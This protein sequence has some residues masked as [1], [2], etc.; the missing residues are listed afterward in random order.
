MY[1]FCGM[2]Y[3]YVHCVY[4]IF[5]LSDPGSTRYKFSLVVRDSPSDYINVTVWGSE[6]FITRLFSSFNV[7]DV[8]QCLVYIVHVPVHVDM[9]NPERLE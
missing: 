8:G 1:L 3:M 5:P 6:L 2:L 4:V 7:N 9:Y